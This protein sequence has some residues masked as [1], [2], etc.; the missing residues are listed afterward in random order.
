MKQKTTQKVQQKAKPTQSREKTP[1]RLDLE[2]GFYED[3]E[4][5]LKGYQHD[6][7]HSVDH[8]YFY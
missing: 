1:T 4:P 7:E 5:D 8:R 6:Y 3:L 2:W